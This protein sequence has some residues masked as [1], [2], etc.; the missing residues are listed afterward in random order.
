VTEIL[1]AAE[2]HDLAQLEGVIERGMNTFIEVGAALYAIRDQRLHRADFET[3]ESYCQ[4]R[5]G[6]SDSRARQLIGAAQTVTNVTA[7]GLPAPANEGQARALSRVPESE[8]IEVWQE[9][10]ERTDGKPTA[11]AVRETYEA[12]GESVNRGIAYV[13]AQR[14]AERSERQPDGTPHAS[15]QGEVIDAELVDDPAPRTYGAPPTPQR[16]PDPAPRVDVSRTVLVALTELR[17]ARESLQAL[18][19]PQLARQDEE[20]RRIWAAR[21][22]TELEALHGFHKALIKE[23][24]Q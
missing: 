1:N 10:V 16:A 3:F 21:L 4:Q 15:D 12:R 7:A 17:Q 8:R 14:H 2:L 13:Q 19:A 24:S 9:T 5:W 20:T 18:T 23:N 6:F 22:N 11:A